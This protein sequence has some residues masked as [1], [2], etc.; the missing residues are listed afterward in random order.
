MGE[1][2]YNGS[3]FQIFGTILSEYGQNR[4][5]RKQAN[6]LLR[7]AGVQAGLYGAMAASQLKAAGMYAAQGKAAAQ[8]GKFNARNLRLAAAHLDRYEQ[9]ALHEAVSEARQRVGAGRSAFAANG[10]LVDSGSAALWEQDEAADAALEQ[11]D[12]M[13]QYEDQSWQYRT[14]ANRALAEGYA[15]AAGHAGAAAGAAGEAYATRLQ[16]A[17][18]L[19]Q[20]K[21]QAKE[22]K[23]KR[24][25]GT[26]GSLIGGTLGGIFGGGAG[27]AAGIEVGGTI[28]SAFNP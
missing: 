17:A 18:I 24:W 21:A 5:N 2:T 3:G 10:V 20:A 15:A 26:I 16:Q 22:L 12:I 1:S 11:L 23:K 14:Q 6:A 7:Q 19:S 25:G 13:Q 27:L 9:L 28:G 4:A 8:M